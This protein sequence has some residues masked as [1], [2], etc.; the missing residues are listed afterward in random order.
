MPGS[1]E[2]SW[3]GPSHTIRLLPACLFRV[4][5]EPGTVLGV[6]DKKLSTISSTLAWKIPWTEEPG[7][8]QSMGSLRVGYN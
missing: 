2:I 3:A 5:H 4:Y 7:G 1:A 6:G 8:L